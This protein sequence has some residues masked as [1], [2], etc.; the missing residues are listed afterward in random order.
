MK[1]QAYSVFCSRIH[2]FARENKFPLRVM[3]ELTYDCNFHCKHCYIPKSYKSREEL[4]TKEIFLIL[5]QLKKIGCFYLGFTG[6]EPFLRKDILEI[7]GY[8]KKLGFEI[9]VYTN[10]SLINNKMAAELSRLRLNKIDITIPAMSKVS[11]DQISGVAGSR[12]KVFNAITLL[13]KKRVNLGFKTC[14]LKNNEPEIKEIEKFSASL[15]A[16]HRLDNMLYSRLDGSGKPY[17]Y[18][19]QDSRL[20]VSNY[21]LPLGLDCAIPIRKD[22][23]SV[24]GSIFECG[25]GVTQAAITPAGELKMCLMIDRPRYKILETSLVIAWAKLSNLVSKIKPS[26][27]YRCGKCDLKFY[28]KWCPAR[29]WLKYGLFD[30]CEPRSRYFAM[31]AKNTL[32]R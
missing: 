9:I 20:L 2:S 28:C 16:L 26:K 32:T 8:A 11:F 4:K 12:D 14:V 23:T 17:K 25:V 19:K 31:Q 13:H 7:L 24:T 10:G 1:T 29:G 22:K 30:C 21:R 3:F 5:D 18:G 27:N 15:G 6:G